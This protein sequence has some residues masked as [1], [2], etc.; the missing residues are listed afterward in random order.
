[1]S[2]A[3]LPP[4]AELV[5]R[6]LA[7]LDGLERSPALRTEDVYEV[8]RAAGESVGFE[9]GYTAGFE[10]GREIGAAVVLAEL[11]AA[12]GPARLSTIA[13]VLPFTGEWERLQRLRALDDRPC[14]RRCGRC[15]RCVRAG[16][17]AEHGGDY[18]P[19]QALSGPQTAAVGPGVPTPAPAPVRPASARTAAAW[20]RSGERRSA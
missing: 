11:H 6:L 12:I 4:A 8:G 13:A 10:A 9:A 14:E 16:W 2:A 1:V 3:E 18:A 19:G 17:V 5:A 7:A 15:S 20:P